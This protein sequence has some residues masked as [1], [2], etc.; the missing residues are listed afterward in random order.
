MNR[1]SKASARSSWLVPIGLIVLSLLPVVA[2]TV[3]LV[4]LGGDAPITP[5]NARFI[6][7]PVPVV[8]H[9]L[10]SIIY[11]IL[12]AF[13]FSPGFLRR[14][15]KWHRLAGRVLIP[16]G[17]IVA[18]SGLW[19][20]LFFPLAK[21]DGPARFD[22]PSLYVIRL[23]VGAAM[24]WF[25]VR[26]YLA[27]R[28][29]DILRHRAW[30]MRGY[31]LGLGAGT[32]VFTHIPWFLVPGIHGEFARTVCMAAGWAINLAVAEWLIVRSFRHGLA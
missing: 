21:F 14:N 20:T 27:I 22:G 28:K 9:I 31:A 12:G 8:L 10:C 1:D 29:R 19:M 7:A 23:L 6:A 2:G 16:S 17:L 25:I 18:L 4:Q 30:M 3:R 15:P 26:G 24:T 5:E 11:A 32:Q 13:Q